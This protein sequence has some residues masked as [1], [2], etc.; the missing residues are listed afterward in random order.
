VQQDPTYVGAYVKLAQSLHNQKTLSLLLCNIA[1]YF[2]GFRPRLEQNQH[3]KN[4]AA[5]ES[6]LNRS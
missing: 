6:Q 3:L 4:I 5:I 1:R 2:A